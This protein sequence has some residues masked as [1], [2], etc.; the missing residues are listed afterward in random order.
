MFQKS[1]ESLKN[2]KKTRDAA[3]QIAAMVASVEWNEKY[4]PTPKQ[5]PATPQKKPN[6]GL[7]LLA[8]AS[9]AE[10]SLPTDARENEKATCRGEENS[11]SRPQKIQDRQKETKTRQPSQPNKEIQKKT[12]A[13]SA[14]IVTRTQDTWASVADERHT[15]NTVN[16]EKK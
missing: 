2:K 7:S 1:A 4:A 6:I 12:D 10:A 9:S 8:L 16:T 11:V 5:N 14:R 15:I 13:D 3:T